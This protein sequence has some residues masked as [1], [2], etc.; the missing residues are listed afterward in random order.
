MNYR[1]DQYLPELKALL[2]KY[3]ELRQAR[4][5]SGRDIDD[6]DK[7]IESLQTCCNNAEFCWS[8]MEEPV[9]PD[10]ESYDYAPELFHEPPAPEPPK[11]KPWAAN[12]I[13]A[14]APVQ[15]IQEVQIQ[16]PQPV[17]QQREQ[18]V[19]R[20]PPEMKGGFR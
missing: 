9:S 7:I 17:V 3:S 14:T 15:R 11:P 16:K 8:D 5:E 4:D 1:L 10:P 6:A 13:N 2:E 19:R 20:K 12:A 18:P